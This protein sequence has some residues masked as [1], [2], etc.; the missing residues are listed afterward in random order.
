MNLLFR[1][2]YATHANGTHHKLA[3]DALR[4]LHNSEASNWQRLF[5]QHAE[6]YLEGSKAP[7][8][9]FKDF[10]NHV[11][12]VRDNYWGGA[13]EKVESWYRILVNA[14]KSN[15]WHEAVW[16]A[17]IM[18]HY[19]TDP[20]H[21]FHT[22]QSTAESNI[23]R[24]VEWSISKSYGSL[25]AANR[26]KPLPIVEVGTNTEW[27][28]DHVI[29]GAEL[30]NRYYETLIAHYN[31]ERGVVEPPEGLD[32]VCKEL[33]SDLLA[34]AAVGHAALLDRAFVEAGV[35]PP[36][37]NLTAETFVAALKIPVK[38]VVRKLEDAA[39]RRQVEAM[40]DELQ[41]TGTVEKNLSNDDRQIRELYQREVLENSNAVRNDQRQKR[42]TQS[43]LPQGQIPK[44]ASAMQRPE[45]INQATD[46]PPAST[47]SMPT[48]SV[49]TAGPSKSGSVPYEGPAGPQLSRLRDRLRNE[50][51]LGSSAT[52]TTL[53]NDSDTLRQR[54]PNLVLSDDLEAAPSIGPK[55]AARFQAIRI[56][57]VAEFLEA[58]PEATAAA[59][60]TRHIKARTIIEWQQQAKL[61]CDLPG[62]R[63]GH[64]QL[65]V[66]AGLTTV[67]AIA[68]T[69]PGDAMAAILKFAQTSAGQ[70]V[71]RDDQPPDLEKIHAWVQTAREINQAA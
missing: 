4:Y 69:E 29:A 59:L 38:W 61:V 68:E 66:G 63:G 45:P 6:I 11:L 49:P 70:S 53:G 2:V 46:R 37:V 8:K 71:L 57:T 12:H 13:P 58:D 14:L 18:S 54:T 28:K 17:G 67:D 7:D 36:E 32:D 35:S 22:A 1:I 48:T 20:I 25:V 34:Y 3:L 9:E 15:S 19:Y 5:L 39:D 52:K 24:A 44:L 30:S 50:E 65:L 31:F 51:A 33:I 40:Y 56:S 23:H 10:K 26:S 47:A 42:R 16:A 21:P 64:A 62:I 27:I 60:N 55:T 41:N 43:P